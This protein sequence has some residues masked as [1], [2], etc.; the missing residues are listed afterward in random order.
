[1]KLCI[2]GNG[3]TALNNHNSKFINNC[4]LVVRIGNFVLDG[5]E[6][7]IGS[8]LDI[9][10]SRWHKCK[11]RPISFFESLK[12]FWIPRTYDTR[13]KHYDEYVQKYNLA[14]K[15]EYIPNSLIF[16]YKTKYPFR[17]VR[18]EAVKGKSDELFCCIPDSGIVAID[19]AKHFY[20]EYTVYITG[21]DNC[22]TG[23]YWDPTKLLHK[24]EPELSSLQQNTLD[25]LIS[26]NHVVN[27]DVI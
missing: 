22:K 13:E 19:L 5:Y 24:P 7:Y 16:K 25:F 6:S 17:Y 3:A 21:F 9:Y 12:H 14:K 26:N 1:M 18:K 8:K 4:D 27:L 11:N 10:I 20:P 2:V 23:Y 15:I